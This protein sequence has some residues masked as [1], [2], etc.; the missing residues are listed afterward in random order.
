MKDK[1]I[2]AAL[3]FAVVCVLGACTKNYLDINSNPYEVDKEQMEAKDYA[4]A[5]GLSAMF[6]TVVST[7]VNTAQFTDCL[8]GS[9]QGGYYADANNGW[10]NTIS[11]YNPTDNWTNVFM[12][13]DKVIP[14]LYSN[15]SNVEGISEDPLVLAILKIVKVC[16]L[17]RVTDTYG[18]IPYSE[19]G[20]TG[21][22][23]VAYD[24]QPKVYSQMFDEL[25]EAIALLD[26]NI[27]RSITS[28]TDQVFDGTAVKWCRFANS[29]KLRLAMR[30]VYT[31]F[32]SS[33]GLSPQQ[34]GE[35]AVAHSVGVMQS[36]A[37][38]AQLSSLAFGK[39]GNPLY[40][41]CMY[42]SPAGSVTGGDSHA[43][44]DIICYMNGYEDPRREKYF[45]KAQFSGDN[46]LEYVGMRR[47]IAIPALSTVGLLYSGVNF[48]DGMAT[49]LQW[50]NAAEVA[51]LKAEAV[52]VFGWNM[53]GSAK[54]FY[55]QGVRLSF[56]Q[57][58]VAG[59]DEYLVGTTLPESYTDPNGG[60][61]SYSTQL[62]QLGVAWNDGASKEEKAAAAAQVRQAAGVVSEVESYLS[63][64]M[65]YSPVTGEISTIIAEE[66]ELVGSG[67]PVVAILDMSD[68]WVTFNVKETLL[69]GLRI[70]TRMNGYVPAL[71]SDVE[72]EVTYISPQADF[73]TWSA[74]RT[75]GGFDIRTFAI[76]AKAVTEAANMRPGMS[77]LVDWD[78][79][80][81]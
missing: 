42:N 8:L 25:D 80:G 59:V 49:P 13:S 48:V 73:A 68:L 7:D 70:G 71:D 20:S 27:D 74:T 26:E 79:I 62:S 57:W 60:A 69:P 1:L 54:T 2:K 9:T 3:S 4:I 37:D 45:S 21:K 11:K 16:V 33:K 63:D 39:D 32:V 67:Y 41:A 75:Q 10:T 30:V 61:T 55:E 51:F 44:A 35:Q 46:A 31:D 38:N 6:G 78:Q 12:Y 65:V 23:Q 40:T 52:G 76:K 17:N 50:M 47:G 18:P 34:L 53:G 24:D 58:G 43:A 72:F 56:E 36:N 14:Q 22:I 5:S 28:T 15:M 64:A 29:M 19:I 66:G 81:K 77:V